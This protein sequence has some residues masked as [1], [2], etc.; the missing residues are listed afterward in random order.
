MYL[1][2]LYVYERLIKLLG[3]PILVPLS[4]VINE[5]QIPKRMMEKYFEADLTYFF[6]INLNVFWGEEVKTIT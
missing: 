3:V 4:G 6:I 5:H 2:W 1:A